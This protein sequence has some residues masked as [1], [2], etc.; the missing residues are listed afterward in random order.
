MNEKGYL[1]S[2]EGDVLE[3]QKMK[4]VFDKKDIDERGE[5]PPPFNLEKFNFNPHDIR[6]YFD[7]DSHGDEII[8]N[9]TNDDGKPIDKLGRLVNAQGYLID[10]A[11]NLVDKRG[12]MRL[13]HRFMEM[14]RGN[15][16]LLF[17]YKGKKYDIRD[18]IGDFDKDRAGEHHHP[19]GP[20]QQDGGQEGPPS[21]QQG[22]PAGWPWQCHQQGRQG[23][24]RALH[25]LPGQRDTQILPLHQVQY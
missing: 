12:R 15:L 13:H 25:S 10:K 11:G 2:A 7:R 24:L 4:K 9:R 18:V 3:N 21:Q 1:I 23:H 14:N 17:N 16:P 5:I 19:Q 6:G 8:G 22:L 20:Q